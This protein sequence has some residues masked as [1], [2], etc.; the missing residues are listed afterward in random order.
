M[1]LLEDDE[2]YQQ[3]LV[4]YLDNPDLWSGVV[5]FTLYDGAGDA[6]TRTGDSETPPYDNAVAAMRDGWRV[7]Q[8]ATPMASPH[9]TEYE[10]A[11][12]RWEVVLERLVPR[13]RARRA[14]T[15]EAPR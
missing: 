4:L 5:G 14:E 1:I 3:L 9:G 8:L 6:S 2:L 7:I 13:S 10:T 11:Y 12:L 15:M